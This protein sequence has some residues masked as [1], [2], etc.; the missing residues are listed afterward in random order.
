MIESNRLKPSLSLVHSKPQRSS[1]KAIDFTVDNIQAIQPLIDVDRVEYKDTKEQGLYL[2]VTKNGVKTFT[3]VGRPKGAA[4]VERK[5]L[6]KF[7]IVKPAEAR[8][9]ARELSGHQASGD[10]VS[11]EGRARR[12]EMTLSDLW[13]QY[14]TYLCATKKKPSTA[15]YAWNIY[16]EPKFGNR[17]LSDIQY[18]EIERWHR[19]L[20]DVII[21]NRK[22]AI[23]ARNA[24]K[25]AKAAEIAARRLVRKH[26]PAPSPTKTFEVKLLPPT[27]N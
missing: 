24:E 14:H 20:P 2:R 9:L 5:T 22:A 17:R 21:A 7:P 15:E 26:G 13:T 12:L 3:Y 18:A 11:A 10:S 6:G 19:D 16:I 23:N 27:E 8:R 4:R 1:T 25:A